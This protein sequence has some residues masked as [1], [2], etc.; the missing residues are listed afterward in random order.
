M[1]VHKSGPQKIEEKWYFCHLLSYF[2]L[3]IATCEINSLS[4]SLEGCHREII[5]RR[6]VCILHSKLDWE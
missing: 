5:N 6:G 1:M 4:Y 2:I 3:E